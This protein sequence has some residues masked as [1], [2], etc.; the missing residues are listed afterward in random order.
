[1]PRQKKKSKL[2]VQ[3]STFKMKTFM[4][5]TKARQASF[6]Y[7]HE[8]LLHQQRINYQSEYDR[9]RGML[10]HSN[11]PEQSSAR[12]HARRRHLLNLIETNLYPV[13]Q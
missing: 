13:R 7:R 10:E 3:G 8:L 2:P 4:D 11:L 9:V 5:A 1:M 12:L 6:A